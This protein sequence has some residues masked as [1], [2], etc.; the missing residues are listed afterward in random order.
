MH[1]H[2]RTLE[3]IEFKPDDKELM[4]TLGPDLVLKNCKVILPPKKALSMNNVTFIDCVIKPQQ[5]LVNFQGWY[6]CCL[7]NCV[8]QG[9]FVGNDFGH[10]PEKYGS[11]G[12]VHGG[13]FSAAILD[14]CRFVGCDMSLVKLPAWP[15]FTI[16]L[17]RE[18]IKA[19]DNVKLPGTMAAWV[20]AV[21][22]YGPP[23][24]VAIVEYAPTLA[25]ECKVTEVELRELVRGLE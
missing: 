9:R 4:N 22:N 17:P 18:R 24:T 23:Q 21:A 20:K 10:F 11:H 7:V 6:R 13:D 1:I 3:N 19:L 14:G 12:K 25:K 8:F 15:C 16:H 2:S 5:K